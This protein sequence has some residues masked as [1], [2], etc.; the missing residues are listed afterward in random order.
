LGAGTPKGLNRIAKI[1]LDQLYLREENLSFNKNGMI[2]E[3]KNSITNISAI[4]VHIN[5]IIL[6]EHQLSLK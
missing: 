6:V 1:S 4:A 5:K 2:W 3:L